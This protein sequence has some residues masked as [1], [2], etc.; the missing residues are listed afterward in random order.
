MGGSGAIF[1]LNEESERVAAILCEDQNLVL[2]GDTTFLPLPLRQGLGKLEN[3]DPYD[4]EQKP[5]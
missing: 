5:L 3:F 4:I 1:Y 2:M